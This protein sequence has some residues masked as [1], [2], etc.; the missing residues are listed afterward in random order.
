MNIQQ[1]HVNKCI[2]MYNLAKKKRRNNTLLAR[3]HP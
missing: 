2:E 1:F 3:K